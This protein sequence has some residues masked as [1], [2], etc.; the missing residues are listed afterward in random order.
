[1]IRVLVEVARNTRNVAEGGCKPFPLADKWIL[2][3]RCESTEVV[4]EISTN[5]QIMT[6]EYITS[7]KNRIKD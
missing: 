6:Y 3:S 2:H 4:F 1:M 7:K 5:R